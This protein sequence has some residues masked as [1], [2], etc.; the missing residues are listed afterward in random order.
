MSTAGGSGRK[1]R[2]IRN[3]DDCPESAVFPLDDGAIIKSG[4]NLTNLTRIVN[5]FGLTPSPFSST[6]VNNSVNTSGVPLCDLVVGFW[7]SFCT[8]G[9]RYPDELQELSVGM[10]RGVMG[11]TCVIDSDH[12]W[13]SENLVNPHC[14][15]VTLTFAALMDRFLLDLHVV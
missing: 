2:S 3:P 14:F 11:D 7:S 9:I 8:Q 6:F 15:C 5:G 4:T 10:C 1:G 13:S 12:N